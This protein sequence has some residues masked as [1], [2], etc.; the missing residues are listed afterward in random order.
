M[1]ASSVSLPRYWSQLTTRDFAALDV[2]ATV[3]VLPLGA[4]E[5]HGPHLPLGVDTVLADGIVAASLP[6]LPADLPVLF[7]PTQQIGLSPE[8]ARFAGTLTLSA[9]TVI[10]MWKEIGAGVA[11]AGVKKL[12]LFNAHGGHVGAMDIVARELRSEHGLIVYSVSWFNLPLGDAGAQFGDREHRFGVHAGDIETSM[13]L[14][15]APQQVRMS[16]AKNFRSTSEQRA[17]DYAIL[18]NGKSAKL[19]WAMEDY[20]PQGAA[21]NAAAATAARGQAVVDA[22]AKQL[23]LL[24]AEVSRLPL[25]TANTG[26]LP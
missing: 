2:A 19:G 22:A 17:A 3:A 16:E 8:H 18:G 6:L 4:T 26:P 15:L 9:E 25:D 23:A 20:N 5:Q 21:G 7:L 24:L 14:A 10:R 12:V 13:M 11:R 1:N